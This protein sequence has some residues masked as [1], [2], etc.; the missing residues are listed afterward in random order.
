MM[1]RRPYFGLAGGLVLL[2]TVSLGV[3]T[4]GAAVD[5]FLK[6]EGVDGEAT[7][8]AHPNEIDV[9]AWSWGL[10]GPTGTGSGG[11]TGI[12]EVQDI[13]FVK[14]TDKAS[15]KLMLSCASGQ[16]YTSAI[17][18]VRS[19]GAT[20]LEYLKIELEN[21]LISSYSTGGSTGEDRLTENISLNFKKVRMT[22]RLPTGE[23]FSEGWDVEGNVP[24]PPPP[25]AGAAAIMVK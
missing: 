17:L 8:P 22:Y 6:I 20:P 1:N 7:D 16:H 13:T 15:P 10:T 3:S 9:L 24:W 23:E 2:L 21:V 12:A 5:M 14:K 18:V 19:T 4:A 25:P 11:G